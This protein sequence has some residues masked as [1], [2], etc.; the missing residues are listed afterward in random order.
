MAGR[1]QL[2][3]ASKQ[4]EPTTAEVRE[5]ARTRGYDVG[6]RGRLPQDVL[7]AWNRAHRTRKVA[8]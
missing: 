5:W 4:P 6:E 3:L 7:T 2:S 1:K 8:A